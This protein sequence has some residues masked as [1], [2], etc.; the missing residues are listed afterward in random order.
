[1]SSLEF[2]TVPGKGRAVRALRGF[3]CGELILRETPLISMQAPDNAEAVHV[4]ERCLGPC[5]RY[6]TVLQHLCE[7][8]QPPSLP[9]L[10]A[11]N[12]LICV[13][14]KC[15][16]G[17]EAP[18]C[19]A[20]CE[21]AAADDGHAHLCGAS[22]AVDNLA[23]WEEHALGVNEA[24][25]FGGKLVALVLG[26]LSALRS[27]CRR[28]SAATATTQPPCDVC[29]ASA[30]APLAPFCRGLW[31]EIASVPSV[32]WTVESAGLVS[33]SAI[34]EATESFRAELRADACHSLEL[35]REALG[36]S[37]HNLGWLDE[38]EWGGLLGVARQ[39]NICIVSQNVSSASAGTAGTAQPSP[40]RTLCTAC[41]APF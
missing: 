18:F 30:R 15:R 34:A 13:E 4:C 6:S 12:D 27:R 5:G 16:N 35:L 17:C 29:L 26:R 31:W 33:D 9:G 28:C 19:S 38:A 24:F 22:S 14:V 21:R 7:M 3:A 10:S 2:V 39:N 40:R 23:D 41:P 8:E 37:A 20:A 1:M 11:A 25:L 32:K 36:S